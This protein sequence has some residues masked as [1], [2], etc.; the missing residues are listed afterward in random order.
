[1]G[2]SGETVD[3][4][5]ANNM[6]DLVDVLEFD[7]HLLYHIFEDDSILR[8]E[9]NGVLKFYGFDLFMSIIMQMVMKMK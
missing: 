6:E 9:M 7:R 3:R 1:M 5:R 2:I 8:E 4:L